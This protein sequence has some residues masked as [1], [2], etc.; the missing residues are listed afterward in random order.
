MKRVGHLTEKIAEIDNLYLALCQARRGKQRKA[1]VKDFV[2]HLEGNVQMLREEILAGAV[3]V[4][5]YHYFRIYD[6]KERLIC[7]ADFRERV[8]HHALMNVCHEHFERVLTADTFASRRGKGVYA[9]LEQALRAVTRRRFVV[10]LDYRKFYDSVSHEV[11]KNKLARLFKDRRLLHI[12]GQIVD[13]YATERGCGLPIGNLTSQYFA[14]F[15]LAEVDHRCRE[16]WGVQEYVRY[17]DDILMADDH[18]ERLRQCVND[19]QAF[20]LQAL[21][22]RLKPPVFSESRSGMN[23][24][25]YR[26]LPHRLLLSG[27]SKRR[28]RTKLLESERKLS[29]GKWGEQAYSDHVLPLLAFVMHAESHDFRRA[30]LLA[31]GANREWDEPCESGRQL[32]QQCQ[33]LSRVEP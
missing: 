4:G 9:A 12:F 18:A 14:N 8:L 5:R 32:E 15:Y 17:M 3:T 1:E 10:K 25:G 7:A 33:E 11:L 22:L 23:F 31:S 30:C 19:L 24:L 29:E 2:R 27:R 6:P 21:H 28:F 16:R 13:S 20:S 26:L